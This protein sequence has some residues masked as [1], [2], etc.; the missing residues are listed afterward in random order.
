MIIAPI[1]PISINIS[2]YQ[3]NDERFAEY[4]KGIFQ[5]TNV[6]PELIELELTES[7]LMRDVDLAIELMNKLKQ[8]GIKISIDDFGT[9]YS[10]LSQLKKFPVDILKIDQCFVKDLQISIRDREIVE[11][12]VAMA[13]KLGLEVVAEGNEVNMQ[14]GFLK[15]IGC[16]SGQGFLLGKPL[17]AADSLQYR[18]EPECSYI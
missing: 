16:D 6:D 14:L 5:E 17:C 11:A 7:M 18:Y 8:I 10:S 9:G 12:I 13:H 1:L 15:N 3:L 2:A 4:V